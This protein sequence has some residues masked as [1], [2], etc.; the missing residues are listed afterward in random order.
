MTLK[1]VDYKSCGQRVKTTYE[2]K[3]HQL[4]LDFRTSHE[5]DVLCVGSARSPASPAVHVF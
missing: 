2:V 5:P 3:T 4:G 1:S